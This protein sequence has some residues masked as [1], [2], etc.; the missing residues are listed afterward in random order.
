[1][2]KVYSGFTLDASVQKIVGERGPTGSLTL[3]QG[4]NR[5]VVPSVDVAN[6]QRAVASMREVVH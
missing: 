3:I 6:F 1:M 2:S 5:I 4:T